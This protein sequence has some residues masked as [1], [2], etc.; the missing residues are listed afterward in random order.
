[1]YYKRYLHNHLD[2]GF[3]IELTLQNKSLLYREFGEHLAAARKRRHLSQAALGTLAGFSRT[4]I[5]NIER[6]R[7]AVQLHHIYTFASVLNVDIKELWPKQTGVHVEQTGNATSPQEKYL[8]QAKDI[9][10][11]VKPLPKSIAP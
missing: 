1:L 3:T 4:S 8:Q 7:Q 5:T 9:L 10:R 2:I 6:G 11:N